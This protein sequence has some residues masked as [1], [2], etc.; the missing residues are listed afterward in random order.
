MSLEFLFLGILW[1]QSL[2][3]IQSSKF[4]LGSELSL[5]YDML[6][7]ERCLSFVCCCKQTW[8]DWEYFSSEWIVC[9]TFYSFK[10][11]SIRD[12]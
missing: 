1:A 7:Y 9:L 11:D 5:F 3:F 10:H 12:S 4:A 8:D 2:F 6:I